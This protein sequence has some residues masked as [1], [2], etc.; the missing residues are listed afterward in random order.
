[1]D[2]GEPPPEA[3]RRQQSSRLFGPGHLGQRLGVDEDFVVGEPAHGKVGA[4]ICRRV[5]ERRVQRQ[6]TH[7]GAAKIA[8]P[9]PQLRQ[10]RVTPETPVPVRAQ[11]VQGKEHPPT[12]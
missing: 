2:L 4:R 1:M 6:R 12:T 11:R 8:D 10:V 3:V 7:H 9:L 5:E